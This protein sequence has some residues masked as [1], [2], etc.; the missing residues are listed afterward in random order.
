METPDNLD[1][2]LSELRSNQHQ[3]MSKAVTCDKITHDDLAFIQNMLDS[4]GSGSKAIFVALHPDRKLQYILLNTSRAGSLA[5][6]AK[7]MERV[8][9]AIENDR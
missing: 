1:D 3:A 8:A 7:V 2:L 9:E 6:L 4:I 5:L